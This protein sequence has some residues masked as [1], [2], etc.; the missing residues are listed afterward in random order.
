MFQKKICTENQNTNFQ[1]NIFILENRTVYEIIWK[2]TVEQGR[3]QMTILSRSITCC[4][5]QATD[6]N[7]RV[8]NIYSSSAI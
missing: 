5:P 3:A 6:K 8:W 4:F 1:L 7:L 2:N